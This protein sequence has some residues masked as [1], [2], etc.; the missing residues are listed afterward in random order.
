MTGSDC[1]SDWCSLFPWY[2]L[3]LLFFFFITNLVGR[4]VLVDVFHKVCDFC[5]THMCTVLPYMDENI[6]YHRI[7]HNWREDF[8]KSECFS[9]T[10][11][12]FSEIE[13]VFQE[14]QSEF[15]ELRVDF[16]DCRVDFRN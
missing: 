13:S 3:L 1:E 10:A 9:G 5:E 16:R 2:F 6:Q 8:R 14:F 11:E 7:S 4:F 12:W 15:Q